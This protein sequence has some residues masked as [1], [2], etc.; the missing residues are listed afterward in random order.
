M[1]DETGSPLRRR[2]IEDMTIRKDAGRRHTRQS[3][4]AAGIRNPSNKRTFCWDYF[5]REVR[6]VFVEWLPVKALLR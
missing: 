6:L 3:L 1:T 2:M 4:G 5:C